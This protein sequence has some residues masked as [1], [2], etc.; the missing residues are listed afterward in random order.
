ME[1]WKHPSPAMIAGIVVVVVIIL[2][3][4]GGIILLMMNHNKTTEVVVNTPTPVVP[5]AAAAVPVTN[6]NAAPVV[7]G[8]RITHSPSMV[9]ASRVSAPSRKMTPGYKQILGRKA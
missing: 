7:G 5:T 6:A 4:I 2:V 3:V 8:S 9:G 1:S